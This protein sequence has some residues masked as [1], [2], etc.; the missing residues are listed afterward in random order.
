MYSKKSFSIIELLTVILIILL[1]ISLLIPIFVNLKMNARSAICMNNQRQIG[2]LLNSYQSDNEMRLPNDSA[3]GAYD[4]PVGDIPAPSVGNN[5]LYTGWQGHLLPYFD[6]NLPDKYTRRAAVT[7]AGCTRTMATLGQATP[8][9]P[10][11]DVFKDGWIVVDDALQVGG[12]QDLRV[13]ICPE[14][15]VNTFDIAVSNIYNGLRIPRIGHLVKGNA[16]PDK[17]GSSYGLAGGVPTTYLANSLFFGEGDGD[18]IRLDQIGGVSRKAMLIEGGLVDDY[19]GEANGWDGT[20]YYS[21]IGNSNTDGGH[22][23]SSGL[24]KT[25]P[26]FHKIS[27]VHDNYGS[28]W[29]MGSSPTL[30]PNKYMSLEAKS[31]LAF[32]FNNHFSGKA[33]MIAGSS[34][35]SG[36]KPLS[37]SIIS[38]VYP[39]DKGEYF[40]EFFVLNPPG[41]DLNPFV[42]FIDDPNEFSYLTGE[43]NVLFGDGSVLKKDQAWLCN[44]RKQIGLQSVD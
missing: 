10:P 31:D 33:W 3:G 25:N 27:Y 39:G 1:L 19:A 28:F 23:T 5:N 40:K 42:A 41:V 38:K 24:A 30:F 17:K 21:V 12:Y 43:M 18:S 32:K 37:Y 44:N 20:V 7:K 15:H 22:L 34:T 9:P 26:E 13:F 8:N 11:A 16:F 2:I 4:Q 29:I 14:I 6:I 35:T 36:A